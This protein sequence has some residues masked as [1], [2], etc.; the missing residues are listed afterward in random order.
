MHVLVD[1]VRRDKE[2][3][4]NLTIRES[5]LDVIEDFQLSS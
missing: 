5:A 1:S 3:P 4:G 2:S